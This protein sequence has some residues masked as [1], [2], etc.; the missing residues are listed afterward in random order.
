MKAILGQKHTLE[1]LTP[2]VEDWHIKMCLLEVCY[3]RSHMHA[4][5][6]HNHNYD[7][8]RSFGSDYTAA[9]QPMMEAHC[10]S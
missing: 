5:Q 4:N 2:V 10:F 8:F 7:A 3:N 9:H 1:G 6:G